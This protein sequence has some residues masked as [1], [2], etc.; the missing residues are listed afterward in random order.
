LITRNLDLT[1]SKLLAHTT[2]NS[3]CHVK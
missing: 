3:V 2:T 1:I